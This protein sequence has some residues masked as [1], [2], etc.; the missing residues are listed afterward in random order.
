MLV[1]I[2][3]S[4]AAPL[5]PCLFQVVLAFAL[6]FAVVF[7]VLKR[8]QYCCVLSIYAWFAEGVVV[9]VVGDNGPEGS[10][11]LGIQRPREVASEDK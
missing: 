4:A 1:I 11:D 2:W 9:G 8:H 5:D 7:W 3:V 10:S 6:A